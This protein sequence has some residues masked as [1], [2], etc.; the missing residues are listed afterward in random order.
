MAK[1]SFLKSPGLLFA[2]LFV[3]SGCATHP[4]PAAAY[5]VETKS[6]PPD[7]EIESVHTRVESYGLVIS[8]RVRLSENVPPSS[9]HSVDITIIGTNGRE[10]RK[11]TSQYYPGQIAHRWFRPRV[12]H[13]KF[14]MVMADPPPAGSVVR[15]S[16]T[17]VQKTDPIEL[18]EQS[19]PLHP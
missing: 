7:I 14:A 1:A 2:A 17:P 10:I 15:V 13:S 16:L 11:F 18:K 6:A 3:L 12:V 8:G 4:K 5:R 19:S 9:H